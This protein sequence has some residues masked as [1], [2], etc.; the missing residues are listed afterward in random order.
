M[1]REDARRILDGDREDYETRGQ[2]LARRVA[3]AVFGWG[4]LIGIA[5]AVLM[6]LNGWFQ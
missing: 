1:R 3:R 5:W 2:R 4:L 6:Y